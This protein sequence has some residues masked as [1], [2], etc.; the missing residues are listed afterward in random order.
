VDLQQKIGSMATIDTS[1]IR[2]PLK[3]PEERDTGETFLLL[4]GRE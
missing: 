2:K 3:Q 1:A 4:R